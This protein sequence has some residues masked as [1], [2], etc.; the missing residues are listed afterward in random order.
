MANTGYARPIAFVLALG[1]VAAVVGA[2][3]RAPPRPPTPR[4]AE[5]EVAG[6]AKTSEP[7]RPRR[8]VGP[9]PPPPSRP[10]ER[11]PAPSSPPPADERDFDGFARDWEYET[12][13]SEWTLNLRTFLAAMRETLDDTSEAGPSQDFDVRCRQSVCRIEGRDSNLVKLQAL[14]DMINK[15]GYPLQSETEYGDGGMSFVTY[16][17]KEGTR[18]RPM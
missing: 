16:L 15:G 10:S 12:D 3:R 7:A 1:A 8:S 9:T 5:R 11:A 6:A 14:A 4:A 2:A 17:G 13:N 18:P